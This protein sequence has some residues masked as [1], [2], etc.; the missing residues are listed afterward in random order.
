MDGGSKVRVLRFAAKL[1][2]SQHR[3][4]DDIL[5]WCCELY[6]C[7]MEAWRTG[8]CMWL[9]SP[10]P[11]RK[12]MRFSY[13]DNTKTFTQLRA[14]DD[15]WASLDTRVGRGVLVRL[16]RAISGF[17]A[18]VR[19]YPRYKAGRRWR[20]VVIPD[21][22]AGMLVRPGEGGRWWRLR[23][24][25]LPGL[26]FDG[27]RL[28]ELDEFEVLELRVVRTALRVELHV[29]IREP[30]P[31]QSH[32]ASNP[33]GLD[34]GIRRRYTLSDDTVIPQRRHDRTLIARR[35]RA[36]SR[37]EPGSNSY[38]KKRLLLAA[39]HARQAEQ[40]RD[41][42][43]RII[44]EL[45]QLDDGFA[46]EDLRIRNLMRNRRL[47]DRIM[48]Q[49]WGQFATRLQHQA[50]RAGLPFERV[51]PAWTSQDCS[52]C[53]QR[54]LDRLTL[55]DRHFVCPACGLVQDRDTNAANNICDRGFPPAVPGGEQPGVRRTTNFGHK[56]THPP[57]TGGQEQ[58]ERTEQYRNLAA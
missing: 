28:A 44:A 34:A 29:V 46:V 25:G 24:K 36:L 53:G 41:E 43:F 35:Q 26:K 21:A 47:A 57:T 52:A 39:A 33:V 56:T 8:Y 37:A 51:N 4:L 31:A 40:R 19:G 2:A 27:R 23:V 49:G 6:N 3:R 38:R 50:E 20:S 16:D 15:R 7:G 14:E 45:L 17:F 22:H 18:G 48:Q 13:M 11:R 58:S 32:I 9:F 54:L 5:R 10:D 30:A 12:K 1:S 42:D 55:A